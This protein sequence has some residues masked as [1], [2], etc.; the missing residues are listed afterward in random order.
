MMSTGKAATGLAAAHMEG[1]RDATKPS[2]VAEGG[3]E[4]SDLVTS[5]ILE[6][7]IFQAYALRFLFPCSC[8]SSDPYYSKK[9][10]C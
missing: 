8:L 1:C 7:S 2:L 5:L 10:F 6:V 4:S 9:Y 3:A